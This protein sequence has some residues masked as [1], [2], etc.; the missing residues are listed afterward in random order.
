RKGGAVMP[1]D[2]RPDLPDD[3]HRSVRV[4]APGVS[5]DRRQL[6]GY[7]SDDDIPR[8]LNGEVVGHEPA[9]ATL[10]AHNPGEVA[11]YALAP[12]QREKLR[13]HGRFRGALIGGL[14]GRTGGAAGHRDHE[15][16]EKKM[17]SPQHA[18]NPYVRTGFER[19][20]STRRNYPTE[21]GMAAEVGSVT[22]KRVP[23]SAGC[24]ISIRPPCSSTTRRLK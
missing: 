24:S 4:H 3:V 9:G 12:D 16:T 8:I 6:L 23:P 7:L 5:L 15:Q 1:P 19:L 11:N 21:L 2:V 18:G 10:A 13:R 17:A 22:T 20:Q 14:A